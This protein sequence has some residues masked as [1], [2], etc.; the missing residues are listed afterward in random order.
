MLYVL[1]LL[2]NK[3]YFAFLFVLYMIVNRCLI[4]QYERVLCEKIKLVRKFNK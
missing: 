1:E 2:D 3:E 4:N